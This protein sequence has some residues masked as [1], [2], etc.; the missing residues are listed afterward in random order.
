MRD[1]NVPDDEMKPAFLML[2]G[3]ESDLAKRS[4]SIDAEPSQTSAHYRNSQMWLQ[5]VYGTNESFSSNQHD[6]DTLGPKIT[7]MAQITSTSSRNTAKP[8]LT[9]HRSLHLRYEIGDEDTVRFSKPSQGLQRP[10]ERIQSFQHVQTSAHSETRSSKRRTEEDLVAER[11]LRR[12]LQRQLCDAQ[13]ELDNAKQMEMH[14]LD[15]VKRE[16][17]SR[18]GAED[19]ATAEKAR[20]LELQ[21]LMD[22]ASQVSLQFNG[23]RNSRGHT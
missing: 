5:K 12:R 21:N 2:S 8:M 16:V 4:R 13:N 17:D 15:Q 23:T 14:A 9:E 22:S 18:R 20:R 7:N 1:R 6:E 11:D 10:Q 19:R 3:C